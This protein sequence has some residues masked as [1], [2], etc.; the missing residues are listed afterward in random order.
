MNFQERL[1]EIVFEKELESAKTKIIDSVDVA[2]VEA[3]ANNVTVSSSEDAKKALDI[4]FNARKLQKDLTEKKSQAI[5]NQLN[6]Q[7]QVNK[8]TKTYTDTL[9][10]IQNKLSDQLDK[11]IKDKKEEDPNF[12]ESSIFVEAGTVSMSTKPD[13]IIED[14][15]LVPKSYMKIDTDKIELAIKM[16]ACEIPGVKI[17]DT[18]KISMR[19][20]NKN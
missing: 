18:S 20:K 17:F 11:F 2:T 13:F 14:E 7:K 12:S 6:F 5:K 19:L 4:F 1:N 16:G 8:F 15:N 10:D 3:D 9:T